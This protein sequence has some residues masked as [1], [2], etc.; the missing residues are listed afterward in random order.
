MARDEI[1]AIRQSIISVFE[2]WSSMRPERNDGLYLADDDTVLFDVEPMQDIGWSS[3]KERL[4]KLFATFEQFSIRPNDDLTIH[5]VESM[6]WTTT[7]W[8][9]AI[10]LKTGESMR[11]AGRGTFILQKKNCRWLV[12]HDH[13]STPLQ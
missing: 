5:Q 13:I 4:H 6:G 2:N 12:V 3:Q 11:L 10:E 8:K 7:T 9:A 1:E